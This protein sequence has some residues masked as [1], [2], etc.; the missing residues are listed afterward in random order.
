MIMTANDYRA[1]TDATDCYICRETLNDDRV[2]D[3]YHITGKYR[4]A[5]HNACNVKLRI[6]AYKTKVPVVFHNL[7]GYD[8]HLIM[9][10]LGTST[11]T[12]GQKISCIPN[13]MEKYTT[14]SVGQLQF[15]DGLQFMNGSLNKLATNLQMEDLVITRQGVTDKEL[16]LPR[17]KGVY[18][19]EYVSGYECFDERRLPKKKTFYSQLTREHIS[20]AD[21]QH[22]QTVWEAFKCKTLGDYH[23]IYLRTDVLFLADVFEAFRNT[24]MQHY[25]LDPAHYFSAPG[26]SWDALLKMTKVEL[27]LSTDIDMHLF[28]EKGL[29]GGI[30]MVSKRFAKANNPQCPEYDSTKITNGSCTWMRTISMAWR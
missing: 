8:S 24:S 28:M 23:D 5:A 21:Y 22:A 25:G 13:N 18:P 1:F 6:Y 4:G 11:T 3:H 29:R 7:R 30:C 27:E 15:I 26:M 9:S 10:A 19:Y 2:R 17:R 20:D 14:F 12:K 16:A